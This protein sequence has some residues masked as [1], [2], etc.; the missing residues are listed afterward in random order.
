M[1]E[2]KNLDLSVEGAWVV[3]WVAAT[4][5]VCREMF[6]AADRANDLVDMLKREHLKVS[7]FPPKEPAKAVRSQMSYGRLPGHE[8]KKTEEQKTIW[9]P[10][11]VF[12]TVA[13]AW[14]L[15]NRRF[16]PWDT[17]KVDRIHLHD[18]EM[19]RRVS[20]REGAKAPELSESERDFVARA[21]ER[22]EPGPE[23]V[24]MLEKVKA[25]KESLDPQSVE[26][27]LARLEANVLGTRRVL[28]DIDSLGSRVVALE[29]QVTELLS[30]RVDRRK[31][32]DELETV[33]RRHSKRLERAD[34]R[35][36]G[37]QAQVTVNAEAAD[38]AY[39]GRQGLQERIAVVEHH[40]KN[41]ASVRGVK[42]LDRRAD[43]EQKRLDTLTELHNALV[44]RVTALDKGVTEKH[45]HA[46]RE[47][48][49]LRKEVEERVVA[50]EEWKD[51]GVPMEEALRGSGPVARVVH[52]LESLGRSH[53][54]L[55]SLFSQLDPRLDVL[56]EMAKGQQ[57]N[58]EDLAERRETTAKNFGARLLKLESWKE[59]CS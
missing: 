43:H 44:A 41:V 52:D 48:L 30:S 18:G 20:S 25:A 54:S 13:S 56:E 17:S 27:R 23:L 8:R 19:L 59:E 7:L 3:V 5:R 24:S 38:A 32:V 46:L 45:D 2:F 35:H 11:E 39:R 57:T 58:A 1:G 36:E 47:R 15:A 12:D 10:D 37:L 21:A 31:K 6:T 49:A 9:L 16:E 53:D 42:T 40:Y 28:E 34:G 50:L 26:N 29:A 22:P 33:V 4:G 55:L 14:Q 51:S